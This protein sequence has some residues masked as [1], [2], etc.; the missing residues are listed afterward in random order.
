M[1]IS[2]CQEFFTY[3]SATGS[4]PLHTQVDSGTNVLPFH[5]HTNTPT[6]SHN[7]HPGLLLQYQCNAPQMK[8]AGRRSGRL[9][10]FFAL[11]KNHFDCWYF[12]YESLDFPLLHFNWVYKVGYVKDQLLARKSPPSQPQRYSK[13][14]NKWL[15][16]IFSLV[17]DVFCKHFK[18]W[19][20]SMMQKIWFDAR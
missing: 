5:S 2:L 12:Q 13:L 7:N 6:Q 16:Q 11:D 9:E 8:H 15:I 3:P 19:N 4:G 18:V 1:F 14:C 20:E 17:W 10:K